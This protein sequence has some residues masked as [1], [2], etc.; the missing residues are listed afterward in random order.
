MPNNFQ[1]EGTRLLSF[2]VNKNNI[3]T[4]PSNKSTFTVTHS[5]HDESESGQGQFF[6]KA[7]LGDCYHKL[8]KSVIN[9][10]ES[11]SKLL[12]SLYNDEN[13]DDFPAGGRQSIV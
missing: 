3:V 8:N 10:S 2:P 13:E 6:V 5:E 12:I 4:L 7:K 11:F 1:Q 9:G